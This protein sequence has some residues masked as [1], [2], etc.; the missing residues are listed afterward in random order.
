MSSNSPAL[1]ENETIV[2]IV[3]PADSVYTAASPRDWPS[4]KKW[5]AVAVVALYT[6]ISP[7]ASAMVA[8]ALPYISQDLDMT[9]TIE[10]EM[11]LSVFVLAYAFG[12]L[13]LGPLSEIYG[14]YL[15]LQ[16]SMWLFVITNLACG[17]AQTTAQILVLRFLAGICGSPPVVLAG[18]VVSDC[19]APHQMG[20]AMS[21]AVL[22]NVVGP[23][24]G[25]IL[26]GFLTQ[27]V[28]WRWIFHVLS[29]FAAALAL[30]GTFLLPETYR[31]LLETRMKH[32][33]PHSCTLEKRQQKPAALS[34]VRSAL[35]TA[36]L[37][38]FI[39]LTTQPI[40]QILC[41]IMMFV[42]GLLF[43]VLA[44]FSAL[45]VTRYNESTQISTL[46]YIALGFGFLA[47]N[48]ISG[49]LLDA[50]SQFFQRR[51]NS[52]HKPE[53]CLPITIPAAAM[54]PLTLLLYGWAA[55]REVHWIVPD[56]GI[57]LASMCI[58]V[59]FQALTVYTVDVYRLY[60]AS[61]L[62]AIGVLR[63]VAGFGFP[64]FAA[65]LYDSLGYGWGNSVLALTAAVLGIPA[66]I[67]LYLHGEKIRERSKFASG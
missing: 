42:F 35:A 62:A 27:E 2:A 50:C 59:I 56:I 37:R 58:N 1:S 46:H 55:E 16:V 6:F 18:S 39:M 45:Y 12:P 9:G 31:P 54:L 51:Y 8:P 40:V 3:D 26:G 30:A 52:D 63:F 5:T 47:G 15:I 38:P 60:S 25:P 29:I 13:V 65:N 41:V 20:A 61:G 23:A 24:L 19:F 48:R 28:G 7:V 14:R 17:L 22:G 49:S 43:I 53:F 10:K 21:Y 57:M 64:L 11:V 44:T 34:D 36:I 67:L 32:A 4:K 33:A 66:P